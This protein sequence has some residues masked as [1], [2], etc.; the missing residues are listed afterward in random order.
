MKI[1]Q[2]LMDYLSSPE[3][4]EQMPQFSWLVEAEGRC[5]VQ[6]AYRLQISTRDDFASC[7]YDSGRH[8]SDES[9]HVTVD[10]IA[11]RPCTRYHVRAMVWSG[12]E[13]TPWFHASFLTGMTDSAWKA[14]F[15]TAERACDWDNSKGTY[16]RKSFRVSG[17][18]ESAVLCT[19]ALGLYHAYLN[20]SAV[21]DDKMAPGWTSYHRHLC[22]QTCEVTNLMREGENVLG[23]HLGA[24]WYKGMMGFIHERNTYGDRTAFLAQL[25][26]RYADGREETIVTDESWLGCNSPVTFSE[27][28]D[29]ERYDARLEQP[30]WCCPGFETPLGDLLPDEP[31]FHRDLMKEPHTEEEKNILR[32]RAAAYQVEDTLWRPVRALR[33]DLSVL[34][35][36]PGSHVRIE[37]ELPVHQVLKTPQGDCVLDF[38]QNLTGYVRF[39]VNAPRGALVHLRCFE[40]LD[41]QGNAYFD[42]L[43]GAAAEI[44]YVCAGGEAEHDEL[45]SFQ[46]FR[47]CKVEAWPGE[48]RA[49][50]FTACV[51]CSEM[52]VKGSFR[53]SHP[54]VNQLQ[55]NIEWS[56]RGNFLDIPTDCPQRDERMG[57][58]GD[59][60]IFCRTAT[61]LRDTWTFFGKWLKDVAYD[62]L[63]EGGVPHI[64]PNQLEHFFIADWLL[65]QGTHSAA[66]WADVAVIN[67][68][69]LYQA[70]GDRRILTQQFDSM[71]RWIDFMRDHAVNDIWNYKLQFGDWVALDAEEGSYYGATPNDLTCTAYYAYSTGLFVKACRALGKTELADE[72]AAL[73]DRVVRRFRETFLDEHG[74]MK[75]Q[76]QTAHVIAL[77]FDLLPEE[78]VAGTVAGLR[79][80]IA[81]RGGHLVTGFVGTPYITHALSRN[82]CLGD[83]YALLLKEDFPSWLYQVK[84][85]ATTIW[86]HWDGLKPDGTMWSPDMNSFNHYAYGA[87]GEWLYRVAAGIEIDEENPGYKHALLAPKTG[88]VFD[89]V[90]S[91]YESVYGD[92][93]VYWTRQSDCITLDVQVPFNTTATVTLEAGARDATG[94]AALERGED[95]LMHAQVGSGA[96][97]FMY[98]LTDQVAR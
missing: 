49:G 22:Y 23:A 52:A 45:F 35:P 70:Y 21:S 28:Y 3:G 41:A 82:G 62:Q 6:T 50:Q 34:T 84:A 93:R 11:L 55:H 77:Y 65:G 38:G 10:G 9:A 80:L 74:V 51:I 85:G 92:V 30:G 1:K 48:V 39:R 58:T 86:E 4:V 73:R 32:E 72:Y 76:T 24:G 43:R 14:C 75:V 46:G 17:R 42:N 66:A 88:G 2:L 40:T 25:T 29:G 97:R 36:Q 71:K 16:V 27:I 44:R 95:G 54:L 63:P 64:V 96:W 61:F 94:D 5:R 53:C 15:I 67:P 78:G 98:T 20:G 60:Q 57:W 69:T 26:I 37:Q 13:A 91:S 89:W 81:E 18:V 47:Y 83:A 79:R 31:V 8:E 19:T 68:W 7:C 90:D 56:L 87:I 59:A 12:E 33:R